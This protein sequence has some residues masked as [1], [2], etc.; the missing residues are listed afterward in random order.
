MVMELRSYNLTLKQVFNLKV[1]KTLD[2]EDPSVA[3]EKLDI[4]L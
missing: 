1:L 3:F 2:L 4:V